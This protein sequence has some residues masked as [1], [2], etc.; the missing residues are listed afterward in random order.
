MKKNSEYNKFN[1]KDLREEFI[2]VERIE[3]N[4]KKLKQDDVMNE[5]LKNKIFLLII[6]DF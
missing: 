2:D 3:E 4:L 5:I 6:L 1:N